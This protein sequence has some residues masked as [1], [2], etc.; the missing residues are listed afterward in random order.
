M[1][2][3]RK[4]MIFAICIFLHETWW[5]EFIKSQ[6]F[7][8]H[9]STV[10]SSVL[11]IILYSGWILIIPRFYATRQTDGATMFALH[12]INLTIREMEISLE[13]VMEHN[14][15]KMQE[16]FIYN[17]R[18]FKIHNLKS[19]IYVDDSMCLLLSYSCTCHRRF[20]LSV[21]RRSSVEIF[22]GDV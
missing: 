20:T 18:R 15:C 4:I 5:N 12:F 6:R 19:L 21:W 10:I 14:L 3:R 9:N 22:D 8:Y 16:T 17:F 2:E 11:W 7:C 13:N 1:I